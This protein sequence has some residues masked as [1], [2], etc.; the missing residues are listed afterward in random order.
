MGIPTWNVSGAWNIHNESFLDNLDWVNLLKLK[1]TY[2]LSCIKD[3]VIDWKLLL[4]L[5]IIFHVGI[6]FAFGLITFFFSMLA[7]LFIYFYPKESH[8]ELKFFKK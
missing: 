1:T 2:G 4:L 8:I 5:G 6:I 3:V 7:V